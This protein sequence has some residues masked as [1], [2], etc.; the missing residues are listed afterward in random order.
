[1][2]DEANAVICIKVESS[3]GDEV[4]FQINRS[5]RLNSLRSEYAQKVGRD[6][7][8]VCFLY[9]GERVREDDT[10]ASLGM[11]E[12]DAIDLMVGYVGGP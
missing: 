1:M 9:D 4:F 12:G 7:N 6:L 2:S 8:T 11:E 5:T 3:M 10:P